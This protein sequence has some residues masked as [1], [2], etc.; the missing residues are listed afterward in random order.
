MQK[1]AF[2]YSKTCNPV[3]I[4]ARNIVKDKPISDVFFAPLKIAW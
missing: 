2:K 4:I 1:G 3:K